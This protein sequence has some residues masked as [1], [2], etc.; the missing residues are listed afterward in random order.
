MRRFFWILISIM[1][2]P[3]L[4]APPQAH[5]TPPAWQP[6]TGSFFNQFACFDTVNSAVAWGKDGNAYHWRTGQALTAHHWHGMWVYDVKC[7]PDGR[8]YVYTYHP[9]G[10]APT[11]YQVTLSQEPTTIAYF[12]DYIPQDSSNIL[13]AL[14]T[15]THPVSGK[16]TQVGLLKSTDYGRT[17]QSGAMIP[18]PH[19][20]APVANG[21]PVNTNT[22]A[23]SIIPNN[24][25]IVRVLVLERANPTVQTRLYTSYDGG[26]RWSTGPVRDYEDM[27]GSY[28]YQKDLASAPAYYSDPAMWN[29]CNIFVWFNMVPNWSP[30]GSK[31]GS[32]PT[33]QGSNLITETIISFGPSS[34]YAFDPSVY[35]T[36]GRLRGSRI[37]YWAYL[38]VP[39]SVTSTEISVVA[40][41]ISTARHKVRLVPTARPGYTMQ[42]GFSYDV[43]TTLTCG[44]DSSN[45]GCGFAKVTTLSQPSEWPT[46]QPLRNLPPYG[47]NHVFPSVVFNPT[48]PDNI[49]AHDSGGIHYSADGGLSWQRIADGATTQ[50][51]I[52]VTDYH[53]MTIIR[54]T[55]SGTYESLTLAHSAASA[56]L[57]GSHHDYENSEYFAQTAHAI[58]PVFYEYWKAKGGL[59]QFGYPKTEPFH[60]VNSDG[61]IYLVQYFERNRF[62]YHPENTGTPYTVLLGLIGNHYAERA[63]QLQPGLFVRQ[64]GDTEPGQLYFAETGHTLRNAFKRHWLDTGGLAQYGFPVS[65]EFYEVN[66]DDGK[67]Y[68]VQYFERARFEWHPEHIGTPYEVLL[69]LLGNQLLTDKGW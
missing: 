52:A 18:I 67:T 35:F 32:I 39:Y 23:I 62:E 69:G 61:N 47:R 66:P 7:G 14:N 5:A 43:L 34:T 58:L 50:Q 49:V 46:T 25:N 22:Y 60:E 41:E 54:Q 37:G 57:P 42:D 1:V 4:M 27:C 12:P 31:F 24:A 45:D 53:P 48:L 17:W 21:A 63:K 56:T 10:V 28:K 44:Y 51:L 2:I 13:Y 8:A 26:I 38:F 19:Q 59:A 30:L 40:Y 33:W 15:T 55:R 6:I 9:H 65:E 3:S 11:Y 20:Y 16:E 29:H 64:N 68:V 36:D